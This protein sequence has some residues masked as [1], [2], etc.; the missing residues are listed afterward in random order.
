M[1][2]S[3]APGLKN[4]FE[5]VA[6]EAEEY[7]VSTTESSNASS[8]YGIGALSGRWIQYVGE[9]A[10]RGAERMTTAVKLR[11]IEH[12]LKH[13]DPSQWK[14]QTMETLLEFQRYVHL[15]DHLLA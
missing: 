8:Y 14:R 7:S 2:P 5:G 3:Y 9:A 6:H 10:L 12:D 11:N 4:E 1:S 15:P 13:G